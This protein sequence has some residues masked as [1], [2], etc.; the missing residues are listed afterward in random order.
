MHLHPLT[1]YVLLLQEVDFW[2]S[3]DDVDIAVD[4]SFLETPSKAPSSS[5]P[6]DESSFSKAK[7]ALKTLLSLEM[8]TLQRTQR[9]TLI[10][11]LTTLEQHSKLA[12]ITTLKNEI[13][14]SFTYLDEFSAAHLMAS[15]HLRL[16][17]QEKDSFSAKQLKLKEIKEREVT[18]KAAFL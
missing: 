16:F 14:E 8:G 3:I 17:L 5:S 1:L 6:S 12:A 2:Y 11:S 4:L 10:S 7:D 18:G 9:S 15:N 13:S